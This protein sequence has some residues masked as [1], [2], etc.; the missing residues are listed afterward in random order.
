MKIR[1]LSL[2][3]FAL[4]LAMPLAA[5]TIQPTVHS[6][7][8]NG[9]KISTEAGFAIKTATTA[10]PIALKTLEG[11]IKANKKGIKI[12]IGEKGDKALAKF[13]PQLPDISG[14]YYLS[15]TPEQIV[16]IGNDDRGTF[17]GVQT[18]KQ[19]IDNGSIPTVEITDYPDIRFRGTVEGFYGTPWSHRDRLAQLKF[20][21]ENKLNTYIY[22]PKDDPYHSSLSGHNG[23]MDANAGWRVP[24]PEAEGKNIQELAETAK[25]YKVDF[26][27]A[28][29][30]GQDI[31][32]NEE[33]YKNLLNKF[34][35]MYQLGVRSYA[36]FFDDISGEGTN[37]VK[38]A[39]LLNRLNTDFVKVKG[40]VTPL[41]MCPTE[42]N[43]SWANPGPDGYLSILGRQLDPSIQIMWT[44]NSVCDD[45]TM[46]TLE[47]INQR[48]QRPTYIWWNFPVTDY[49]RH[50]LV[51]GPSYGLDTKAT[52]KDMNGFVSNP[53]E[54]AEASKIALYGVADYT[55]NIADYD[56]LKSWERGLKTLMPGAPEAFRTFA[57]HSA[58]LEQNGHGFRRDESWETKAIDPLKYDQKDFDA[59]KTEFIKIE[60]APALIQNSGADKYMIHEMT[61]WLVEFE[62][63]GI[64]GQKA[65]ELI[66]IY[67]SG[68]NQDIWNALLAGEMTPEQR[69]EYNAHKSGTLLLQPFITNTYSTIS[70][71]L[72]ETL[73]GKQ[74]RKPQPITSFERKETLAEMMD[75]NSRTFYY[76]WGTQKPGDWV[77]VDLGEVTPVT[78]VL[79]EQGRKQGDND[80]FQG[81]TL[82]YSVDGNSWTT[83]VDVP[84]SIYTIRYNARPIE[85]R[86][87]RLRAGKSVSRKNWTAIRRFDVNPLQSAPIVMTNLPQVA[88]TAVEQNA[89]LV[90]LKPMLEII[91][92]APGEYLGLELPLVSAIGEVKID[93]NLKG[94]K[95][96]YSSN[97]TEWS[98]DQ[99]SSARYIRYINNSSKP[100]DINL[101]RF[102]VKLTSNGEG[103]LMAAFDKDLT[104]GFTLNANTPVKIATPDGSS[105]V[106]ILTEGGASAQVQ[107]SDKKGTEIATKALNTT[108]TSIPITAGA[109]ELTITAGQGK[110]REIIFK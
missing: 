16:I 69:K 27:W 95:V 7:K 36:V 43:K 96:E 107:L 37:P 67:K 65:L 2:S 41:I 35:H 32:W 17:Y 29:H 83:L 62:K 39:E 90:S 61:P 106:V 60:K 70:A 53:M 103:D 59:L 102:E 51:Q 48:I 87:V 91:K 28:I 56:Y 101:R 100:V 97:G 1:K 77:G 31:K 110:I 19:L 3:L 88:K 30:P 64:R 5:Q 50:L 46:E 38:Q 86:Y 26:V 14:A 24:Y 33:D 42:Y 99:P 21:G 4:A 10:D 79:V 6:I 78:N 13:N 74:V 85:A 15:V 57:I 104:T 66:Q 25:Q 109:A 73:S 9:S 82:E 84:D 81:A 94:A 52:N 80:Y 55:W 20:Y 54:H 105:E 34:E 76:S 12:Y 44:G 63:L 58:D 47:W 71:K 40:D 11:I 89:N 23:S 108:Y 18:L 98:N 92:V 22:G 75:G 49:V 72:H 93:L 68:N 8:N 45:I